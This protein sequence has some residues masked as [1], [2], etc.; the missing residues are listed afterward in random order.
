MVLFTWELRRKL[1]A[2]GGSMR[3]SKTF[4]E[5]PPDNWVKIGG[6]VYLVREDSSLR[7]EN[8]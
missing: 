8:C 2:D 5:L 3:G 6:S 4:G 1:D 7:L